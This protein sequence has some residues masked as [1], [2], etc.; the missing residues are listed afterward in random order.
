LP[1]RGRHRQILD[2]GGADLA[3]GPER[4]V[5]TADELRALPPPNRR[6]ARSDP[7]G[8]PAIT[9]PRTP[10]TG[11]LRATWRIGASHAALLAD[12]LPWLS[13]A[14]SLTAASRA[15][16]GTLKLE[17][18]PRRWLMTCSPRLRTTL[19]PWTELP[20]TPIRTCGADLRYPLTRQ[21]SARHDW[22]RPSLGVSGPPRRSRP[23]NTS[24]SRRLARS[25]PLRATAERAS[26]SPR[27][28]AT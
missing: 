13:I 23:Q 8:A 7:D 19:T 18:R 5:C 9:A 22:R 27:S 28:R 17:R 6:R 2:R 14:A 21:A 16:G 24:T 11:E 15:N 26:I 12:V 4:G 25:R 10:A 3:P 1:T 20:I